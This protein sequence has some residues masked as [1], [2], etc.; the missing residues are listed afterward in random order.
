MGT[1]FATIHMNFAVLRTLS[2]T[3]TAKEMQS[4]LCASINK[5]WV[6]TCTFVCILCDLAPQLGHHLL[7]G[8]VVVA[9]EHDIA[10]ALPPSAPGAVS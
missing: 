6:P 1:P 2:V 9:G 10:V 8:G 5:I 4:S 7:V 3:R